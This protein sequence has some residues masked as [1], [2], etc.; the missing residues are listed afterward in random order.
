M[1][2]NNK[3]VIVSNVLGALKNHVQ[4]DKT[5]ATLGKNSDIFFPSIDIFKVAMLNKELHHF[6][7]ELFKPMKLSDFSKY[8]TVN[9]GIN[10]FNEPPEFVR[11]G[12]DSRQ[13]NN[14]NTKLVQA[15]HNSN[16]GGSVFDPIKSK[17]MTLTGKGKGDEL[18][19]N[20]LLQKMSKMNENSVF[21]SIRNVQLSKKQF[22]HIGLLTENKN[23]Q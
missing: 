3:E 15:W 16:F 10:M 13:L 9:K 8:H 4:N 20:N 11:N 5:K 6:I 14:K 17:S 12:D 2:E 22:V 21:V 7:T 18:K 19:H 23:A 1:C